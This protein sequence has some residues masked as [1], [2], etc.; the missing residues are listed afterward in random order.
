MYGVPLIIRNIKLL[1]PTYSIKLNSK[2]RYTNSVMDSSKVFY[3]VRTYKIV[4]MHLRKSIAW[5]TIRFPV[6]HIWNTF[7][8]FKKSTC[9]SYLYFEKLLAINKLVN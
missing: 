4:R 6:H 9:S 7:F 2:I 1:P 8:V 5:V 3:F